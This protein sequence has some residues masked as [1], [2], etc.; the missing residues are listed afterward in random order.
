MYLANA[1]IVRATERAPWNAT[2]GVRW[3][4]G[5]RVFCQPRVSE[6][7][8]R[9]PSETSFSSSG[10]LARS[11]RTTVQRPADRFRDRG[12]EPRR[13][14]AITSLT[15]IYA[16]RELPARSPIRVRSF[17]SWWR[18]VWSLLV[19][20]NGNWTVHSLHLHHMLQSSTVDMKSL[21]AT[22]INV[23]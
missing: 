16:A 20:S 19:E 9:K 3:F 4:H 6:D 5:T 7:P 18:S 11:P 10:N 21:M 15:A 22:S 13:G 2:V 1:S 12:A 14:F 8:L 17:A 23:D